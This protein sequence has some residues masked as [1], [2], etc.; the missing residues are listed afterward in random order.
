MIFQKPTENMHTEVWVKIDNEDTF[1]GSVDQ[2][3]DCYSSEIRRLEKI[4]NGL[5]VNARLHAERKAAQIVKLNLADAQLIKK[6]KDII[7]PWAGGSWPEELEVTSHIT[8]TVVKYK[9]APYEHPKFDADGWDG[10]GML[11]VPENQ[12]DTT[13]TVKLWI[14]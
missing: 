8:G 6:T 5:L 10:M 3:Y 4:A 13:W 9:K 12:A 14:V 7:F 1:I 2:M 11:Y